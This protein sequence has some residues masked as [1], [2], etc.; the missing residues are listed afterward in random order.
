MGGRLEQDV[1]G[2]QVAVQHAVLV[3]VADGAEELP[4]HAPRVLLHEGLLLHDPLEELAARRNVEDAHEAAGHQGVLARDVHAQ[5]VRVHERLLDLDFR[6]ELPPRPRRQRALIDALGRQSLATRPD[7]LVD[8]GVAAL[9]QRAD[10]LVLDVADDEAI[11]VARRGV[12]RQYS[13]H[14]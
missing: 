13:G 12:D 4:N 3:H 5:Y 14:I 7:H 9:A 6:A 10:D 1:L 11:R 8:E 2:L